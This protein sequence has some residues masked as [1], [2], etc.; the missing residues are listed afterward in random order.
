MVV[1]HSYIS[2]NV[3]FNLGIAII[4]EYTAIGSLF[5]SYLQ[6]ANWVPILVVS[7]VTVTYTIFGGLYVSILTDQ[8]QS[9]FM[10]CLMGIVGS[11]LAA[12]FR[13]GPLPP[14]PPSLAVTEL[15]WGSFV[16]LGVALTSSTL[17]SDAVW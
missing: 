13:P 4:V 1:L 14:L 17:F 11:Y 10:F 12:T 2:L 6:I 5:A 15:G 3:L 9:I 16:T 7:V 8:I